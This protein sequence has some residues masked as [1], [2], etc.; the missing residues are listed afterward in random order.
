MEII[1]RDNR[2]SVIARIG[3][4]RKTPSKEH[5]LTLEEIEKRAPRASGLAL[6]FLYPNDL[7]SNISSIERLLRKINAVTSYQSLPDVIQ[8]DYNELEKEDIS[9][10]EL[11]TAINF[12]YKLSAKRLGEKIKHVELSGR[13]TKPISYSFKEKLEKNNFAG[14]IV[15]AVASS[16]EDTRDNIEVWKKDN[17]FWDKRTFQE[18][19]VEVDAFKLTFR[20]EQILQLIK[21]RGLTNG[22]I[23]TMLKISESTVKMHVGLILKKYGFKTRMQLVTNMY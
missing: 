9:P 20:Q 2:P 10:S 19:I 1:S 14:C 15:A 5:V 11:S 4:L 22:Q 23:A 17:G 3:D 16:L 12:S 13:A 6:K 21:T 8:F 18:K 7:V